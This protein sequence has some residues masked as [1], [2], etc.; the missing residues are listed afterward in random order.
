MVMVTN[1][2]DVHC[3]GGSCDHCTSSDDDG[4]DNGGDGVMVMMEVLS[5]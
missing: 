2:N 4:S 3:D 5:K 1:G